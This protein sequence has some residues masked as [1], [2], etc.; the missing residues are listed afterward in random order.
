MAVRSAVSKVHSFLLEP[1]Q[2]ADHNHYEMG[3]PTLHLIYPKY[4]LGVDCNETGFWPKDIDANCSVGQSS[5]KGAGVSTQ[6]VGEKG[7]GF[8]SVIKAVDVVW[9][10]SRQKR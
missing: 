8:K 10:R 9:S 5:K 1:I 6:Y 2:N 7:I 4:H 3:D